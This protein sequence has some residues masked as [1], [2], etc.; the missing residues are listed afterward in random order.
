MKAVFVLITSVF[1]WAGGSIGGG[2]GT[3]GVEKFYKGLPSAYQVKYPRWAC[4]TT[5]P[6]QEDGLAFCKEK[7]SYLTPG[8]QYKFWV[9]RCESNPDESLQ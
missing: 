2:G 6:T 8:V 5:F 4:W 9:C 7:G 1:V 3:L